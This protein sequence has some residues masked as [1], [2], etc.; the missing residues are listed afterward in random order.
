MCVFNC[1]RE[2][3][4][5]SSEHVIWS[6]L[7]EWCPQP[8]SHVTQHLLLLYDFVFLFLVKSL[9]LVMVVGLFHCYFSLICS[10]FVYNFVYLLCWSVNRLNTYVKTISSILLLF[11]LYAYLWDN[12]SNRTHFRRPFI[13]LIFIFHGLRKSK[14]WF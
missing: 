4:R 14:K 6:L 13:E 5:E 3:G 11:T 12:L 7:R 2:I 1:L 8:V 9:L 10:I